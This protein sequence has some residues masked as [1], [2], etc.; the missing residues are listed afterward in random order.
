[1]D[2]IQK[3]TEDENKNK[4]EELDFKWQEPE[5]AKEKLNMNQTLPSTTTKCPSSI[6]LLRSS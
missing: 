4:R 1:M 5:F 3:K 6:G 2:Y